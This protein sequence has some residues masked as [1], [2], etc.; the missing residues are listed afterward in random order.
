LIDQTRYFK[1]DVV[2]YYLAE[3]MTALLEQDVLQAQLG[4]AFLILV[5][6]VGEQHG[7]ELM[8]T[9]NCLPN[10]EFSDLHTLRGGG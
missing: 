5:E 6:V 9:H 4:V 7:L 1:I 2:Q 3:E 8:S 10:T